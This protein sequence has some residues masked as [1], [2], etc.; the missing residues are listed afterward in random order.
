MIGKKSISDRR[1]GEEVV[2]HLRRHWFVIFKI[3]VLYIGMF[4]LPLLLYVYFY[5]I[6]PELLESEVIIASLA[7]LLFSYYLC[8]LVFG[9]TA[10]TDNYLD[11]WTVTN[12]RVISREQKG[13][14]HRVTSELELEQI[15]DIT[16]EEKGFWHTI[17]NYGDVYIQTAGERG[18]F[19]F[20][21]VP[22]PQQI[23]RIIEK[24]NEEAKKG[25]VNAD[26]I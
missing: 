14:F 3:A 11:V 26:A 23:A 4:L 8:L 19:V 20:D 1:A 22:R 12:K 9:F 7:V 25:Q 5:F 18:R 13:L 2:I 10:W 15:Q 6:T 24:I 17:L 21:D 16:H